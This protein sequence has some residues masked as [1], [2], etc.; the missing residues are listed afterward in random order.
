MEPFFH[1]REMS[2]KRVI[3]LKLR[4]K[5]ILTK[6]CCRCLIRFDLKRHCCCFVSIKLHFNIK[7]RNITT[8]EQ[9]FS[10]LPEKYRY[11]S[12]PLLRKQ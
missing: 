12:I 7:H 11:Q 2:F 6:I 8:T 9:Y 1:F 4:F 5:V 10:P 3:L